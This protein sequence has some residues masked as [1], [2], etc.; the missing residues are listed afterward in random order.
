ML[1]KAKIVNVI[2]SHPKLITFGI[3]FAITFVIG[4]A[5]GIVDHNQ[6]FAATYT[7][8]NNGGN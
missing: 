6:A 5:I 3:G 7:Q 4:I 8:T 2:T 1:Q